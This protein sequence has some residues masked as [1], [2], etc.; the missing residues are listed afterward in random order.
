MT[1]IA[2][3]HPLAENFRDPHR[4]TICHPM[5]EKIPMLHAAVSFPPPAPPSRRLLGGF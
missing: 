3:R 4:P 2:L 1:R 5:V